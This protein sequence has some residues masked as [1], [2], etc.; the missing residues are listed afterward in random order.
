L[1]MEY[2]EGETVAKRLE[3]GAMPLDEALGAG[4]AIVDALNRAHREGIIHRNLRPANIL[5]TENG[6]KLLDFGLA[7]WNEQKEQSSAAPEV[8]GKTPLPDLPDEVVRYMAPEQ[9]EG[10]PSDARSDIFAFGAIFYEM[11]TGEKAFEG[12]NRP[13]LIAA[14]SSL[15]PYP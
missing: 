8:R 1:V 4:T 3:S 2:V 10:R 9:I 12:R 7:R 15:D 11:V 14:I 5:L 13:M 6:V